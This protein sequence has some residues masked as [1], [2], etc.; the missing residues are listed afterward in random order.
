[1]QTQMT[2]ATN[3]LALHGEDRCHITGELELGLYLFFAFAAFS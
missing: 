2:V 1:V 3:Y